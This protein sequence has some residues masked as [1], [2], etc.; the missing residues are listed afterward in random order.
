MACAMEC[1]DSY[2]KYISPTPSLFPSSCPRCLSECAI[3]SQLQNCTSCTKGYFLINEK[4]QCVLPP[5][6]PEGTY[7]E[8]VTRI[9]E[10]CHQ[11]CKTCRGPN[12]DQCI[13]C[14][15]VE[16]YVKKEKAYI[17]G[18]LKLYCSEGYF[19]EILLSGKHVCTKCHE[20]CFQCFGKLHTQCLICPKEKISIVNELGMICTTCQDIHP[21]YIG[22]TEDPRNCSELCGD[23]RNMGI[24]ECDDGNLLD[25]DGCDIY[26]RVETGFA[27]S[28]G[29]QIQPDICVD[30]VQPTAYIFNIDLNYTMTIS[31][32]KVMKPIGIYMF[33]IIIYLYSI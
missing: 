11:I 3:C 10:P 19:E 30:I 28:K 4:N 31:F 20:T 25:G 9:C 7:P 33:I 23:G 32:S 26:C 1:P 18:C 2:F 22:I 5:F 24:L 15:F 16:G 13:I 29:N 6:C 21:G 14:N 27:C 12:H 8:E 17:S